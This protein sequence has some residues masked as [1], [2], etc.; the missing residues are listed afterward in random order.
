[1]RARG[2]EFEDMKRQQQTRNQIPSVIA[3]LLRQLVLL[4]DRQRSDWL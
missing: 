3:Y 1:M 2:N 4:D